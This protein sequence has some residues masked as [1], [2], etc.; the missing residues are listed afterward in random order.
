MLKPSPFLNLRELDG[1]ARATVPR[2]AYDYVA[3]GSGDETT[4]RDNEAAW[5][6]WRL[7][8][9]VLRDVS[10]RTCETKV[11]GTPVSMPVLVAPTAFHKLMHPEGEVATARGTHAAGTLLTASTLSTCSLEEIAAASP[12][13]KWF[14]LYVYKDRDLTRSLVRRAKAAGYGALVLTV[15]TATWGRRERD[16]RNGFTLPPGLSMAN[17]ADLER[18]VLPNLG[19]GAS[20]LSAYVQSL[21]DDSLTWEDVRWLRRESGLPVVVKGIEHPEDARLAVESGASAVVVSNH[22]GRQLDAEVPTALALPAVAEAVAGR[23]E[24]YVDGG[25]RRGTDVVVA[26]A[27]GARA[28]LVGRPILWSLALAGAEG[29][30]AALDLLRTEIDGALALCGVTSPREVARELVLRA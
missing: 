1:L 7:L 5:G 15:D 12:G 8:P 29:V 18:K 11:L 26:L 21:F 6:R 13:P 30:A 27:L 28:V 14:Q 10:R 25:V 3:G 2:A 20:G 22:G 9:R 24:V 19:T 4:L 17:F 23:C 16:A